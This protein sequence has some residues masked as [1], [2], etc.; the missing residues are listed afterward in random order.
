MLGLHHII[1]ALCST[2]DIARP[3]SAALTLGVHVY[4]PIIILLCEVTIYTAVKP[5]SD[6]L[7]VLHAQTGQYLARKYQS[8]SQL[9][10]HN[11]F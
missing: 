11:N 9:K 10:L 7:E 3:I 5:L 8:L 4:V 2:P 6:I 1:P